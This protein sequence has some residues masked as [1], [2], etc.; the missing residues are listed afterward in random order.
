M[1]VID[2]CDLGGEPA[3]W[4]HDLVGAGAQIL[5]CTAKAVHRFKKADGQ[6]CV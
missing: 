4:L 5:G 3:V 1:L 6:P 2:P